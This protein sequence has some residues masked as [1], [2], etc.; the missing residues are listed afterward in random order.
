MAVVVVVAQ[1]ARVQI[2]S[3]MVQQVATAYHLA[4]LVLQDG[5]QAVAL[6]EQVTIQLAVA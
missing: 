2:T 3:V 4:F 5:T 6:L 1:V